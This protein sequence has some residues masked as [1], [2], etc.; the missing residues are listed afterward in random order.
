MSIHLK[1]S[2]GVTRDLEGFSGLFEGS[3]TF[4]EIIVK[5]L[6]SVFREEP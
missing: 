1:A 5:Y 2:K 3:W 4:P 6:E